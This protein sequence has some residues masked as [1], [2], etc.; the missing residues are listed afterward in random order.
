MIP[1][2]DKELIKQADNFLMETHLF[3]SFCQFS[4]SLITNNIEKAEW[5]HSDR[6]SAIYDWLHEQNIEKDKL[7]D[8]IETALT[9]YFETN[10][11]HVKRLEE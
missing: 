7:S 11:I 3:Y 2:A 9:E 6:W 4:S 8:G 1:K 10:F 5:L